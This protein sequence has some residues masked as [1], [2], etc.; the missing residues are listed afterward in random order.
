M[1]FLFIPFPCEK[2]IWI[3]FG[4]SH[5][6]QNDSFLEQ[7]L[8][9][10]ISFIFGFPNG[11]I[12]FALLSH[13]FVHF[14]QQDNHP[15]PST[16]GLI[17]FIL[18]LHNFPQN[19]LLVFLALIGFYG[20]TPSGL[21]GNHV[22]LNQFFF[23][24]SYKGKITK[25]LSTSP[26]YGKIIQVKLIVQIILLHLFGSLSPLFQTLLTC[27]L[28]PPWTSGLSMDLNKCCGWYQQLH[29]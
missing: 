28:S 23:N 7:I 6:I 4:L 8:I 13:P 22:H 5:F 9:N 29:C 19:S 16:L 18:K 12:S 17:T 25:L 26:C 14:A 11:P 10:H 27:T 24:L 21:K 15:Q 3:D 20:F 1:L 2:E